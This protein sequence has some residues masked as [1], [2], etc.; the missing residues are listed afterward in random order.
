MNLPPG[1]RQKSPNEEAN[2]TKESKKIRPLPQP[3]TGKPAGPPAATLMPKSLKPAKMMARR[4]KC[5]LLWALWEWTPLWE[6]VSGAHWERVAW[7]PMP[8]KPN[9]SL[10][11]QQF[12]FNLVGDMD[13][14]ALGFH[15]SNVLCQV[16][17]PGWWLQLRPR[18][19][20][21]SFLHIPTVGRVD[22]FWCNAAEKL[23]VL[24]PT[25]LPWASNIDYNQYSQN[26]FDLASKSILE[27]YF[28]DFKINCKN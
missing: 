3:P 22:V 11:S 1:P 24:G 23:K 8:L 14:K 6:W 5:R 13:F 25:K 17:S 2:T 15:Q 4:P 19:P 7:W 28:F 9:Q 18:F 16:L 27:I 21:W 26:P 12:I 10:M 20:P